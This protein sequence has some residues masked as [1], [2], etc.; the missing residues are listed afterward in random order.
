[1]ASSSKHKS[2]KKP[3]LVSTIFLLALL[4]CHMYFGWEIKESSK[5]LF[6]LVSF[7][8]IIGLIGLLFEEN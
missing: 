8:S 6:A 1:M 7:L 2:R 3:V 4:A 5:T